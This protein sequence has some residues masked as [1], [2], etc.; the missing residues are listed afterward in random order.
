MPADKPLKVPV[1]P[2][3]V[4]VEP[5]GDAVTVQL[6]PAGKPLNATLPVATAHVVW[7]T[8][9]VLGADGVAGCVF[10]VTELDAPDVHPAALVTVNV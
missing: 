5:P 1:V 4:V 8:D 9:P 7:V 3:P 10:I 2:V 6:P